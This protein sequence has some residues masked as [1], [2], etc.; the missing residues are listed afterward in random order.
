MSTP[1]R[2]FEDPR[3]TIVVDNSDSAARDKRFA[4][5]PGVHREQRCCDDCAPH[6]ETHVFRD[7]VEP[8][9]GNPNVLEMY[10]G[11]LVEDATGES[12]NNAKDRGYAWIEGPRSGYRPDFVSAE[13]WLRWQSVYYIA[14][15]NPIP[16]LPNPPRLVRVHG[17]R[18]MQRTDRGDYV[19]LFCPR[20][21]TWLES[22]WSGV[23]DAVPVVARGIAM[24]ASYIPVY[25]TAL[26]MVINATVSLAEGEP[27]DQ[28]LV[29]SVGRSLPGQPV[30][31]GFKDGDAASCSDVGDLYMKDLGVPK[32]K[33]TARKW[34]KKYYD[35]GFPT[36][37][38]WM[39]SVDT[40]G[41]T[42]A[43][44]VWP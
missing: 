20:C 8:S 25:G 12:D 38:D 10:S 23:L 30:R 13:E 3:N 31:Q 28:A 33:N 26:S 2:M 7:G 14:S 15:L 11:M 44:N 34:Y 17:E 6:W 5:R 41:F 24:I 27:V 16:G 43:P 32:N 19:F 1:R 39:R 21:E 37:C 36:G 42:G 35:A 40:P 9:D 4:G 18:K 29:D 22:A